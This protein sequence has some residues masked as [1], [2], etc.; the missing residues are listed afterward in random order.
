[1]GRQSF[2]SEIA[3]NLDTS[4]L[5]GSCIPAHNVFGCPHQNQIEEEWPTLRMPSLVIYRSG[6]CRLPFFATLGVR[7]ALRGFAAKS[8]DRRQTASQNVLRC[9]DTVVLRLF[10]N[11][12]LAEFGVVSRCPT[13]YWKWWRPRLKPAPNPPHFFRAPK[14]ELRSTFKGGSLDCRE[15]GLHKNQ[16]KVRVTSAYVPQAPRA[17]PPTSHPDHSI[18]TLATGRSAHESDTSRETGI[19]AVLYLR[20]QRN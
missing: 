10:K 16:Q 13:S 4:P 14:A 18:R 19:S 1:M 2:F 5:P 17:A 8:C 3:R 20:P 7:P 6:H 11:G 15:F 12:N 9:F